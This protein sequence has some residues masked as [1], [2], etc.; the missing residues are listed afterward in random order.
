M[1]EMEIDLAKM[2]LGSSRHA[3]SLLL[4]PSYLTHGTLRTTFSCVRG[5]IGKLSRKQL[6]DAYSVL[7]ELQDI[8]KEDTRST[9][10]L[11]RLTEGI[12]CPLREHH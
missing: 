10:T 12:G 11:A 3:P 1:L 5:A 9:R 7:T 2:P 4:L 8:L 6:L